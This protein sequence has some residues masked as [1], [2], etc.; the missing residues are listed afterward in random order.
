MWNSPTIEVFP[1]TDVIYIEIGAGAAEL[2]SLHFAMNSSALDFQEPFAYHPHIT[3]AQELPHERVEAMIGTGAPPL[4]GVPRAPHIPR[5]ARRFC[6]EHFRELLGRSGRVFARRRPGPLNRT[7]S[8]QNIPATADRNLSGR[9]APYER[10]LC[11]Q[12]QFAIR[13]RWPSRVCAPF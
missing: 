1:Q 6:A 11:I 5:R 8:I 4:G 12:L 10:F 9:N 7:Q 13:S 2:Y 3:L